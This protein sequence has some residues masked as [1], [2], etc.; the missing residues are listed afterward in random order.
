MI[1]RLLSTSRD[2]NKTKNLTNS[3]KTQE[4]FEVPR[5]GPTRPTEKTYNKTELADRR[6]P[7]VITQVGCGDLA[8]FQSRWVGWVGVR[9]WPR[10]W[11]VQE[12]AQSVISNKPGDLQPGQVTDPGHTDTSPLVLTQA[13]RSHCGI[14]AN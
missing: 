6:P 14:P 11:L 10:G 3:T 9:G 4:Q 1:E 8:C 13:T 7:G 2:N 5:L 12:S